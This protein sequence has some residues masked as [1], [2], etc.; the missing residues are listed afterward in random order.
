MTAKSINAMRRGTNS[1]LVLCPVWI[2]RVPLVLIPLLHQASAFSRHSLTNNRKWGAKF[3]QSWQIMGLK[4]P[5]GVKADHLGFSFSLQ[6]LQIC[7]TP[8]ISS[9]VYTTNT[10][11][12]G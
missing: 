10:A 3:D 2:S 7:L 11:F 12:T 5:V 8:L 1:A 4:Q 6:R 9:E